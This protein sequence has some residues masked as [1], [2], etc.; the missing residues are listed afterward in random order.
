MTAIFFPEL[1]EKIDAAQK[2]ML[3]RNMLKHGVN[4]KSGIV[5][6]RVTR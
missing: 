3:V 6:I 2:L 1:S 5:D 4:W